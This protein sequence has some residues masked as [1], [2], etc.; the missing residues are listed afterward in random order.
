[1][2][3]GEQIIIKLEQQL[4]IGAS[5]GAPDLK[6]KLHRTNPSRLLLSLSLNIAADPPE[7]RS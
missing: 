4:L 2:Q 5:A 7:S 1:M 6:V 3:K